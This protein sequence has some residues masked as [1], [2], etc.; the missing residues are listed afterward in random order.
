MHCS[1][2]IWKI[3]LFGTLDQTRWINEELFYLQS[4]QVKLLRVKVVC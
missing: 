2:A 1:L 3:N 4:Y